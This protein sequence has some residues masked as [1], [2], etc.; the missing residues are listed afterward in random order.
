VFAWLRVLS[1]SGSDVR[2]HTLLRQQRRWSNVGGENVAEGL[3]APTVL[4]IFG[5]FSPPSIWRCHLFTSGKIPKDNQ[6]NF[7]GFVFSNRGNAYF[8][9]SSRVR[10]R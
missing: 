7:Q 3:F 8:L 10:R 2:S 1:S 6:P 9:A 4:N 5:I